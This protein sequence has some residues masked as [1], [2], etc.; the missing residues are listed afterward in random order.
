MQAGFIEDDDDEE[1]DDPETRKRR[2]AE[3][4]KRKRVEREE[5]EILDEDDLDLIADNDPNIAAARKLEKLAA[6]KFKR[7]KQGRDKRDAQDD[8]VNDFWEDQE[9]EPARRMDVD[10]MA[11]FIEEDF[12]DQG[13]ATETQ[14]QE[15]ADVLRTVK[16]GIEAL[17]ANSG[18]D[19][20]AIEDFQRAFGDGSE[21]SWA[22]EIYDAEDAQRMTGDPRDAFKPMELK[23]VFEPSELARKFLTDD[24][25][26]IRSKDEPERFQMGR[27][28]YRNLQLTDEQVKQE[29]VWISNLMWPKSTLD[30]AYKADLKDYFEAAVAK[31]LSC[32]NVEELECPYV[33]RHRK[34][35]LVYEGELPVPVKDQKPGE[36]L[37]KVQSPKLLLERDL[38]EVFQLDLQYRA[39]VERRNALEAAYA[40]I[41]AG[42]PGLVDK[43]LE[44]ML[45]E[46][47]TID[48]LQD[49]QDYIQFQYSTRA[50]Q[51]IA[52]ANGVTGGRKRPGGN[53]LAFDHLRNS[54]VYSLVRAFG[55]TADAFAQNAERIFG[56][57]TIAAKTYTE[58]P[59]EL[60]EVMAESPAVLSPPDWNSGYQCLRAARNMFAEE[61]AT[62]PR[63]RR[64]V[65][66][67]WYTTAKFEVIRT[68][69]GLRKIDE[70]HP[71]YEFKYL[72]NQ[73]IADIIH[74]PGLY[75][76]M[77]RAEQEGLVEVRCRL[78]GFDR[79]RKDLM[80]ELESDNLSDVAD[81]WNKERREALS[82]ALDKINKTLVRGV[83]E[84]T[85]ELCENEVAAR[86]REAY[87]EKLDQAP[88][89]PKGESPGTF[90][91]VL[92]ISQG[93][94]IFGKDPVT[95]VALEDDGR[96]RDTS[97]LTDLTLAN[98]EKGTPDGVDIEKL[99]NAVESNN[100]DVIAVS[101]YSTDSLKLFRQI[102]NIV[103][104]RRIEGPEYDGDD[105][106]A[107]RRR[108]LIDVIVVNDEV[109]RLYK[110]SDRA[111]ADYPALSPLGRYCVALGRYV[112]SPLHEYANLGSDIISISFD[113]DQR[114]LPES[115]LLSALESAIVDIVNMVGVDIND[116]SHSTYQAALLPYVAGL[117]PRKAQLLVKAVSL[118]GG[119]VA[120]RLD[121]IDRDGVHKDIPVACGPQ[122]YVNCVSFL[123]IPYSPDIIDEENTDFLDST[124][125]HPEDYELARK[126]AADAIELD[127][128]D[129]EQEQNEFGPSAV[130][131]KMIREDLAYK[132]EDLVLEEYAQQL[133]DKFH[134]RKQGAIETIRVELQNPYEEL[135]NPFEDNLRTDEIFTMFTGETLETLTEGMIVPMM[136]KKVGEDFIEARLDCGIEATVESGEI[137]E[138]GSSAKQF[139]QSGQTIRGKILKIDKR[140]LQATMSVLERELQ[141]PFRYDLNRQPDEWDAAQEVK[142]KDLMQVRHDVT[143]RTQRVIKHPLFHPFN[144]SQAEEHLGS[145]AIGSVVIRPSSKGSDHLVVTWKVADGVYKHIDVLELDKENE[146]TVGRT[147]K[148]DGKYTYSDLD[149]LI[150][151]HVNAMSKKVDEM[152]AAE[153]FQRGTK[154]DTGKLLR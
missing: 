76:R 116:A 41:Q 19:E 68:E 64:V 10:E 7:L 42:N 28:P 141:K 88:W 89:K 37:I 122:T 53:R 108:D 78:S 123:K 109:A 60:P 97:R 117:G 56:G 101:G 74:T 152:T 69:K 90:P 142:D 135:R 16:G 22:N 13:Q 104:E 154:A 114:F 29:A 17:K 81:A 120:N 40:K 9:E 85:K 118:F 98:P 3:R 111:A 146:F 115:R 31:V 12:A 150:V 39:F 91:R 45:P 79:L 75:L 153:K 58:D 66:K 139:F 8:T 107:D 144:S 52:P 99:I 5:E 83:K 38:W 55:I 140:K 21:Y 63:L 113:R 57:D 102:Q 131:R 65:R 133:W 77:L 92:A 35:Y 25:N 32:F 106:D 112:Q 48:E 138:D 84:S 136:V 129:I 119:G 27:K 105:D 2:R 126:M 24:D 30:P 143:G 125:I 34:D 145:Q 132:V 70:Q 51:N 134:Q 61:L 47:Q 80:R 95:Y 33:F 59:G 11:D 127:E 36:P 26:E 73:S 86:C 4:K 14:E 103:Q 62:S 15:D 96:L 49:V 6:P 43:V 93:N 137:S 20:D 72:R 82:I 44:E 94:G 130:V 71:Y 18:L 149:E 110:D 67:E 87:Y 50:D 148:I 100:P 46:A 147:L 124:R 151:N 121:L 128:E 54:S 1:D 23:D